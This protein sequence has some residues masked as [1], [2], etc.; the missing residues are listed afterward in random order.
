MSLEFFHH[1]LRLELLDGSDIAYGDH[2]LIKAGV[3]LLPEIENY[4]FGYVSIESR[5]GFVSGELTT[6][7]T[8]KDLNGRERVTEFFQIR[9]GELYPKSSLKLFM[10]TFLYVTCAVLIRTDK[11][12]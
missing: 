5:L 12:Q 11:H 3:T 8:A 2:S 9:D 6:T 7:L 4:N 10:V 1:P